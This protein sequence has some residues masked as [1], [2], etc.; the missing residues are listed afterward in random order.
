MGGLADGFDFRILKPALTD[1]GDPIM[2][3]EQTF[4]TNVFKW[5]RAIP[6]SKWVKYPGGSAG[7]RGTPDILG[8]IDG[9]MFAIEVKGP[10]TPI[11]KIQE[12][13]I[14]RWHKAGARSLILRAPMDREAVYCAVGFIPPG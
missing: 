5:L 4:Q 10:K 12:I 14:Q 6:N 8:C 1:R 13:E 11:S 7:T 2:A 3:A 9:Q